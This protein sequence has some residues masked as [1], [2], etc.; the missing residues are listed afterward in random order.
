M[1]EYYRKFIKIRENLI[2][3]NHINKKNLNDM[4]TIRN[5]SNQK[6][7][8][9]NQE[10]KYKYVFCSKCNIL[11]GVEM[12]FRTN[13][14]T[15]NINNNYTKSYSLIYFY[16]MKKNIKERKN[17]T[18][19]INFI[20]FKENLLNL[21]KNEFQNYFKNNNNK[22]INMQI[23]INQITKENNENFAKFYS[24]KEFDFTFIIHKMEGRIFLLG[25][26]GYFNSV[27]DILLKKQNSNLYF[28]LISNEMNYVT[29]C[30]IIEELIK[31]GGEK[32]LEK[33]YLNNRLIFI[34][35]IETKNDLTKKINWFNKIFKEV[36]EKNEEYSFNNKKYYVERVEEMYL[37]D[38]KK[39]D[40]MID[41]LNGKDT[42]IFSGCLL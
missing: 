12:S 36:Y 29:N 37:D 20:S 42:G 11:L 32:E 5:T 18:L 3:K 14:I 28:I 1:V 21:F 40:N 27:E 38:K 16:L 23:N 7:S 33:Y 24:K 15:N 25:K 26:N 35:G 8:C 22:N 4:I 41:H 13:N 9:E 34:D 10:K 6:Q 2:I 39:V 31:E 19:N 17:K 30:K